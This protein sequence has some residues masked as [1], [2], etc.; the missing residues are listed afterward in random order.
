M[1]NTRKIF[2]GKI[3]VDYLILEFWDIEDLVSFPDSEL[4]TGFESIVFGIKG[5]FIRVADYEDVGVE[6]F[7]GKPP[8]EK[9][10]SL[11]AC[12]AGEIMIGSKGVRVG[13]EITSDLHV[14]DVPQGKYFAYIFTDGYYIE[15][16]NVKIY[17]VF[18]E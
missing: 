8:K 12:Y 2:Q 6:V 15:A 3:F 5:F 17:L 14:L 4:S 10:I 9:D 13:N 18:L 16:R 7:L 11:I 1:D